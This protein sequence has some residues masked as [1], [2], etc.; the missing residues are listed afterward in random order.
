MFFLCYNF[1]CGGNMIIDEI[2]SANIEALKNKDIVAR[3]LYGVLLN[4]IKL[5]E[6]SKREHSEDMTDSDVF[7]ILQKMIK[8]LNDEK[9]NYIKVGNIQETKNLEYQIEIVSKYLPQ[10]MT[11]EEIKNI[12]LT[13][14]D[15]S[16]P[17]VM[18]YFKTNY[19]G[20]CDMRLVGEVLK[21][22]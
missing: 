11:K 5:A 21:E 12:V 3:N 20:K 10:M 17:T 9:E 2:K 4:K 13:L 6:I 14:E 7:T 15:K 8:E 18:K 1:F 22:I 16:I 19:A